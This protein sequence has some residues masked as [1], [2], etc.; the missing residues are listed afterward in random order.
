MLNDTDVLPGLC[1]RGFEHRFMN[2]IANASQVVVTY[3]VMYPSID[4]QAE[5]ALKLGELIE[6]CSDGRV[7]LEFYPSSQLGDKT[8]TFKGPRNGTIGVT[9]CAATDLSA[10]NDI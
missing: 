7:K 4:T 9:E 3:L 5:G 8:A 2:N 10:F 6:A 1:G